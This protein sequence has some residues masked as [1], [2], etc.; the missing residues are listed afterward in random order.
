MISSLI[1]VEKAT[2]EHALALAPDMRQADVDEVWAAHRA[3]PLEALLWSIRVSSSS[4]AVFLNGDLAGLFGLCARPFLAPTM[5]PWLLTGRAV[6]RHP[7]AFWQGCK[8]VIA[9]WREAYPNTELEQ[10]IDARHGQALRWAAR[11]GF[12]VESPAIPFGVAG[13]PFHRISLKGR[14]S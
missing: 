4:W 13:L 6:E 11:L 10:Y 1:Y 5:V 7:R 9:D 12:E 2:R 14:S 3:T 8:T